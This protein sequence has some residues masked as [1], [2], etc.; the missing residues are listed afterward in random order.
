MDLTTEYP[1]WFVAACAA[2][3]A[4]VAGV[5]YY[6][7]R[8]NRTFSKTLIRILTGIR[9]VAVFLLALLLLNPL[10]RQFT[11]EVEEPLVVF[12]QDLSSSLLLSED[13]TDLQSVYLDQLQALEGEASGQFRFSVLGFGETV[14]EGVEDGFTQKYTDFSTLFRA[15][16]NR[17]G[18]TNL[19]ALV[20]ASDGL[21]NRGIN[22]LYYSFQFPV[23]IYTV[24]LGD[25]SVQRDALIASTR[26]NTIAYRG[27]EFP[28]TVNVQTQGYAGQEV[29]VRILHRGQTVK[30]ETRAV[31]GTD[32]SE[33]MTFYLSS[34]SLGIQRYTVEVES[35]PDEVTYRNN[36]QEVYI[37]ILENRNRI[38][39]LAGKPHPDVAALR[40]VLAANANNEVEAELFANRSSDPGTFNL[41]I[42]H[43]MD[44]ADFGPVYRTLRDRGIPV[45]WVFTSRQDWRTINSYGTGLRFRFPRNQALPQATQARINPELSLFQW[46]EGLPDRLPKWPAITGVLAEVRTS[47]TLTPAIWANIGEVETQ[48]PLLA[49]WDENGYK[50]GYLWGEGLWR[51]R[52]EEY[53]THEDTKFFEEIWKKSVQYLVLKEDRSRFRLEYPNQLTESMPFSL[54]AEF[55]NQS[56]ERITDPEVNVVLRTASDETYEYTMSRSNGSYV[57]D[58]GRLSAGDYSLEASVTF[59][60]ET[61]TKRG[62]FAVSPITVESLKTRADHLL[63]QALAERT[64]GRALTRDQLSEL[65]EI[66]REQTPLQGV[67]HTEENLAQ[68]LQKP[69]ILILLLVLFS[70]E[71][72]LR[73]YYG[74][75]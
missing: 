64:G 17:Y 40:Q 14:T 66:I 45:L 74:T 68:L 50:Q 57:L 34:D 41:V 15:V 4:V 54:T 46:S 71:W 6:R 2:A 67:I 69:W 65:P 21:V 63:L 38:L 24:A 60:G 53:R 27:N 61:F 7:S 36:R 18:N 43:G 11:E 20:V 19:G 10:V 73:R 62:S 75:V 58:A 70:A 16:E 37:D 48:R 72:F 1:L 23:P 42:A 52:L 31:S 26:H 35:L 30:Q 3:A 44:N 8:A 56:Y 47:G 28:I 12:A 5:L 49:F 32:F 13:S 55:Y 9:F 25:S 29:E 22:P 33:E 59:Q 51:W 39:I